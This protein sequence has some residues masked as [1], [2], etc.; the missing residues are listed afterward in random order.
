MPKLSSSA[1]VLVHCIIFQGGITL[2]LYHRRLRIAG[3]ASGLIVPAV[4]LGALCFAQNGQ[5]VE[6]AGQSKNSRTSKC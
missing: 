1:L 3:L 4:L 5:K 6:T 2:N